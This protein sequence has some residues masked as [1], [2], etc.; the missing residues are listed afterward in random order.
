MEKARTHYSEIDSF[1]IQ[2]EVSSTVDAARLAMR[3]GLAEIIGLK[4]ELEYILLNKYLARGLLRASA[5]DKTL[6]LTSKD[7][8]IIGGIP[9]LG[10]FIINTHQ[11]QSSKIR[12]GL[13]YA[14]ALIGGF[15]ERNFQDDDKIKRARTIGLAV[16]DLVAK[17]TIQE[18]TK[19][20]VV[21]SSNVVSEWGDV[22]RPQLRS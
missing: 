8:E 22:W 13:E 3:Y 15:M 11:W 20:K 1:A 9:L 12:K 14:E 6:F 18:P 17:S 2:L 21:F 19:A 5:Y 10:K 7:A 4:S 16:N